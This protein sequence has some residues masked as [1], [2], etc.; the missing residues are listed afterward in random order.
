MC[1]YICFYIYIYIHTYIYMFLH[2][3]IHTYIHIYV[4]IRYLQEP[5][6]YGVATIS[7]LH[8]IICL[9]CKRALLKRLYSAKET[10]NFKEPTNR[11]HP[12]ATAESL[13][14]VYECIHKCIHIYIHTCIYIHTYMYVCTIT[15]RGKQDV[16][17][18]PLLSVY[19]CIYI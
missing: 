1:K 4:Y 7:R 13:L 5:N 19:L 9:F 17:A 18:K 12:I 15:A 10:Y 2:I 14:C 3:H 16:V 11:S 8:K 6:R